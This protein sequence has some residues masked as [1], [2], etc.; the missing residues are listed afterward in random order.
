M[1]DEAAGEVPV[2]FVIRASGRN[3]SEQEI[4]D[5]IAKQV[6]LIFIFLFFKF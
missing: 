5:Y 6:L 1:P 2:A 3:I 4:K